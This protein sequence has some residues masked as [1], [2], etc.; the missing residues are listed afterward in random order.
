MGR[1]RCQVRVAT[2][3]CGHFAP[4]I[5]I[6]TLGQHVSVPWQIPYR[7]PRKVRSPIAY[8]TAPNSSIEFHIPIESSTSL[9]CGD[10]RRIDAT[11]RH[12]PLHSLPPKIRR[13]PILLQPFLCASLRFL[14]ASSQSV[15]RPYFLTSSPLR[16]IPT[17]YKRVG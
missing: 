16:S 2:I 8:C 9:V 10:H 6:R 13:G 15:D 14:L 5:L 12:T 4:N 1:P 11:R 3:P 7:F 17:T